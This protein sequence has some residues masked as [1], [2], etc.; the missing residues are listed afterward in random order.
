MR[1]LQPFPEIISAPIYSAM[2][3]RSLWPTALK[4]PQRRGSEGNLSPCLSLQN[5]SPRCTLHPKMCGS[6]LL[7]TVL[8]AGV[9]TCRSTLRP[10]KPQDLAAALGTWAPVSWMENGGGYD[11]GFGDFHLFRLLLKW[12]YR[13]FRGSGVSQTAWLV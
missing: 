12:G 7:S 11:Y 2:W 10:A 6:T 13:P 1:V 3:K 8:L 9:S 4:P 5:L